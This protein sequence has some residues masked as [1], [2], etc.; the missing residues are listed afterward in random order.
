MNA[1]ILT[2][3]ACA[4]LVDTWRRQGLAVA[5]TNGH[6]DLLHAGHVTYLHAA[7]KGADRLVVGLNSDA[8]T[9]RRKGPTRPIL[10]QEE[11]A[12]LL[13]ALRPV[14]AVIIWAEDDFCQV[15]AALKPD[16][17]IKGADWNGKSGPKPPEA[18]IIEAQGGQVHFIELTP[19]RSTS[20]IEREIL[21]RHGC[22]NE[23]GA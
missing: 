6:F 11:R 4:Q 9:R 12:L 2:L 19:G 5:F 3:K 7:R 16:Y 23:A 15:V 18:A 22:N 17:Y 8:S 13:A 20:S 1:P 10:P 14:D 21:Q